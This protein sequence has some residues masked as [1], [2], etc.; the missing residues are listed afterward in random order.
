ML[1]MKSEDFNRV[2]ALIDDTLFSPKEKKVLLAGCRFA[3]G[4]MEDAYNIIKEAVANIKEEKEAA[5]VARDFVAN[6]VLNKFVRLENIASE[7]YGRIL[8]DV[9]VGDIHLNELLLKERYAVKYDGGTKAKPTSW[10]KYR[11]TNEV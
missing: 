9:Y 8:A 3:A 7:K 4:K 2:N 6:L 10:L 1:Y 11:L 5:K